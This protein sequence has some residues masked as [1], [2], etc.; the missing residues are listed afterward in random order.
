LKHALLA[1]TSVHYY[2][3]TLGLVMFLG[4]IKCN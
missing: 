1:V 3:L 2:Q 4:K